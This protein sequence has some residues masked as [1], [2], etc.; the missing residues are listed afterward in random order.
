MCGRHEVSFIVLIRN[1]LV[2]MSPNP[3]EFPPD[4]APESSSSKQPAP[5]PEF[6]SEFADPQSI[7]PDAPL[8]PDRPEPTVNFLQD[9]PLIFEA[10]VIETNPKVPT[11]IGL[12][13]IQHR[14]HQQ[15]LALGVAWIILGS[16]VAR[17]RVLDLIREQP[18]GDYALQL[19]FALVVKDLYLLLALAWIISGV[20]TCLK[21][22]PGVYIGLGFSYL[23]LLI[24][25][26]LWM[27]IGLFAIIFQAHRVIGYAGLL[28]QRGI[29]LTAKP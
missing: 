9:G 5:R 19:E 1:N 8:S 24:Y 29:S 20:L 4:R 23:A 13:A 12:P 26:N 17:A 11:Q 25:F 14:F 6:D 15:I 7:K 10:P 18:I 3:S 2:S 27:W 21:I 16:L 28:Q 22:M